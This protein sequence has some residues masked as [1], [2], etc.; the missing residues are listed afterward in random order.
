VVTVDVRDPVTGAE[1][2][3]ALTV[4]VDEEAFGVYAVPDLMG[5][6][7]VEVGAVN[8]VGDVDLIWGFSNGFGGRQTI[9]TR[10]EPPVPGKTVVYGPVYFGTEFKG[11]DLTFEVAAID[12]DGSTA[13]AVVAVPAPHNDPTAMI[14]GPTRV[15][16]GTPAVFTA[17][18]A[19]TEGMELTWSTLNASQTDGAGETMTA[20]WPDPA[21]WSES[22]GG[23][24]D[25]V[26]LA[27]MTPDGERVDLDWHYVGVLPPTDADEETGESDVEVAV[28]ESPTYPQTYE[29]T[30][31]QRLSWSNANGICTIDTTTMRMTLHADGTVTGTVVGSETFHTTTE[32]DPNNGTTVVCLEPVANPYSFEVFGTHNEERVILESTDVQPWVEGPF[33]SGPL[34]LTYAR[35][36]ERGL[37]GNETYEVEFLLTPMAE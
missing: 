33:K 10:G 30:S 32:N 18:V 34:T 37:L 11:K 12:S 23:G 25:V 4:F 19:N 29:G 28:P 14:T 36:S 13:H 16:A 17:V 1:A 5:A 3:A 35:V 7:R 26:V 20:T 21:E 2:F 24:V 22:A 15:E 9:A 31:E 27:G 6:P 8:S